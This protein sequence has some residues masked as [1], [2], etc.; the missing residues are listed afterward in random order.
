M[1]LKMFDLFLTTSSSFCDPRLDWQHLFLSRRNNRLS[2]LMMH[3]YITS[4]FERKQQTLTTK[5][6][7][8]KCLTK[9]QSSR[10]RD[11]DGK[12]RKS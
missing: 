10:R 8:K 6:K 2:P 11:D 7:T 1:S 4:L 12:V 3:C 9:L 5:K